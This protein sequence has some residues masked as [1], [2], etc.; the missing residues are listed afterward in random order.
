MKLYHNE[1]QVIVSEIFH[2]QDAK[3]LKK[4]SQFDR[5][6][7][8]KAMECLSSKKNIGVETE[9]QNEKS[10]NKIVTSI[11]TSLDADA[12]PSTLFFLFQRIMSVVKGILNF[13]NFR[14]G[15][16]QLLQKIEIFRKSYLQNNF[17]KYLKTYCD[18]TTN[19]PLNEAKIFF[20]GDQH[21]DPVQKFIRQNIILYFCQKIESE[22]NVVLLEGLDL[23]A[24][25]K[26]L[27]NRK[28]TVESWEDQEHWEESGKGVSEMAKA[29]KEA[30]KIKEECEK[31]RADKKIPILEKITALAKFAEKAE[32]LAKIQLQNAVI[33]SKRDQDL[34]DKVKLS[35]GK[36]NRKIFV[37]AGSEHLVSQNRKILDLF[38]NFRCATIIPK[39]SRQGEK[40]ASKVVTNMAQIGSYDEAYLNL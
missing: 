30:S 10:F 23:T 29:F 11:Q 4:L 33:H 21:A 26:K 38:K 25:P 15:S 40:N 7:C 8:L 28:F 2:C 16:G 39:V 5:T 14:V 35:A 24:F 37:I 34:V 17:D 13:F 12:K 1:A 32:K 3:T 19:G 20:L 9:L 18:V 36:A 27:E 22:E 31:I 6:I